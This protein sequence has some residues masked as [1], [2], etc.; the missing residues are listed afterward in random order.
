MWRLAVVAAAGA[1]EATDGAVRLAG[2]NT[3]AGRVEVHR[4]QWGWI[5]LNDEW[6]TAAA[7]VVCRQLG[8]RRGQATMRMDNGPGDRFFRLAQR[9][10][11]TESS[12]LDCHLTDAKVCTGAGGVRCTNFL[13]EEQPPLHVVGD[14]RDLLG[15]P[16]LRLACEAAPVASTSTL[17]PFNCR[18]QEEGE[19]EGANDAPN[20]F[21]HESLNAFVFKDAMK[22]HLE[23]ASARRKSVHATEMNANWR[24]VGVELNSS[25]QSQAR[26]R[27]VLSPLGRLLF[28]LDAEVIG[29]SGRKRGRSDLSPGARQIFTSLEAQGALEL[30]QLQLP[31][32]LQ[33]EALSALGKAEGLAAA[34]PQLPKLEQWLRQNTTLA[35]A[36]ATYLGGH[37]ML[38]GY[39]VVHLP[40]KLTTKEF[41]AAHWHHDRTG[42]RLKLFIRLNDVDPAEGHPTQVALGSHRLSY[43]WHEE[44]EQSRYEDAYVQKEFSTL[45]LAGKKGTGYLFDTNSIHKGTPEGSQH[46]DVIV[47]EYHQAAKCSVISQLGLNLPCPSGDQRPLNWYFHLSPNGVQWHPQDLEFG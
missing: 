8:L 9:C 27:G 34:R 26:V 14:L 47:V 43:Y 33:E 40:S 15:Q 18:I 1:Q 41:V 25:S 42:R 44:F 10:Q 28:D 20:P 45:L 3:D 23:A 21:L 19:C 17:P 39:K 30:G 22:A 16:M 31:L 29:L 46:R 13:Q 36:V 6:D 24:A 12:L 32:G 5:C 4:G 38:H 35:A 2:G 7:E 37:A 11:G